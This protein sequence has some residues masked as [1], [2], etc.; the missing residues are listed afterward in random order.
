MSS[1]LVVLIAIIAVGGI[2]VQGILKVWLQRSGRSAIPQG[3]LKE[4]RDGV[5]RIE[6]AV[7]AIA[8]EV[9][10]LSEGQRFTAKLLAEQTKEVGQISPPIREG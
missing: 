2:S 5:A 3:D 8:V 4:I 7:D 10:R 6:Q 9:E 1:D